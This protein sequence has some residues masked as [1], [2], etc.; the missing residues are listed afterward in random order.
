[1]DT[2]AYRLRPIAAIKYIQDAFARYTTT[3]KM[4]AFDLMPKNLYWITTEHNMQFIDSL[5]FWSEPITVEIWI[6]EVSKLKFYTD[7]KIY[8]DNKPFLQGSSCWLIL[9]MTTKRPIK[10]DIITQK[11]EV[12]DDFVLGEHTKFVIPK[13]LEKVRELVHTTNLSDIDFNN[14]VNNKSYI[15]IAEMTETEEFRKTKVLEKL[16]VKFNKESFLG[17]KL[18]C[19]AYKTCTDNQYVHNI[20]CNDVSVCDIVTQWK[21]QTYN[22]KIIDYD[23]KVKKE[24]I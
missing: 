12:C 2:D 3:K 1:M 22:T 23:L 9:D 6:S 10:T 21:N 16:Y 5:P 4:A 18:N 15:N 7:Y 17:D 19:Y 24:L 14:H 8:Y 11:F 13:K 20:I